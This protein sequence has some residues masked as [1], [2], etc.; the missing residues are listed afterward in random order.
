MTQARIDR[1][2]PTV[3]LALFAVIVVSMTTAVGGRP[4]AA[5]VTALKG[6]SFG[7]YA[8]VSLFGGPLN[9]RGFGQYLCTGGTPTAPTPVGCVPVAEAPSA[10]SPSVT[11]PPAGGSVSQTDPDGAKAQFGPAAVFGGIQLPA[12]NTPPPSGPITVASQGTTGPTGSV[13][14]SADIALYNP[15]TPAT[16]GG[17]GPTTFV[18]DQVH[19]TCTVSSTG[20][21]ASTTL[22]NGLLAMKTDTGGEPLNVLNIPVNPPPNFTVAGQI[23][24]V[25][26]NFRDV[27]NEQV[28][29]LDGS[30]TVNALHEYL[31]GPTA[32]GDLVVASSTCGATGGAAFVDT[33][34]PTCIVTITGS[35]QQDIVVQDTGS[36]VASISNVQITNGTVGAPSGGPQTPVTITATQTN[37][38]VPT[39][40]SF[41]VTDVAGHPMHCTGKIN[42]IGE[43]EADFDGHR[44]TDVSVFRPS[45]GLW[46]VQDGLAVGWGTSGDIAVPGDYTGDGTTD[47]AVFRPSTG[48]WYV[49]NGIAANFGT[50][51]DVPVPGD[52]NGD[53]TTDLAVFRP[54]TS[55]W[56]VRGGVS[57]TFGT[58][59]D[60]PVPGDYN[61]DGTTDIAVFRPSTGT[62]F[63]RNGASLPFGTLGDIPVP[64]DYKGTGASQFAVFR[65]STG[66][67]F[68]QGGPTVVWGV[69]GDVPV[70][71]DYDHDGKTDYAVFRGGLWYIHLASGVGNIVTGFGVGTDIP[72]PLPTSVY[73]AFF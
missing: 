51:G 17:V 31:L 72:L 40:W 48:T 33:Q 55:T 1:R 26:D 41:D 66:Q 23:T 42:R 50:S 18:A 46:Y 45:T 21:T 60:I 20:I 36:G 67:W 38:R 14:S 39:P 59:G 2:R 22:T 69:S 54:S 3:A 37:P 47:L 10:A 13:T 57:A 56:F 19:S 62:W 61:G 5:D 53:G 58:S 63:V 70:P 49:R 68:V 27:F 29:N 65:P 11:L 25:G 7:Y 16:P 73:R 30:I 35:T 71:G 8:N 43:P 9:L 4:A 32:L 24:N 28:K 6:S 34:A 12:N 15:P 52:Y 64:G 44:D